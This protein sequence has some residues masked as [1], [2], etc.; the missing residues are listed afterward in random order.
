MRQEVAPEHITQSSELPSASSQTVMNL[1]KYLF[2]QNTINKIAERFAQ[3]KHIS[4]QGVYDEEKSIA[5]RISSGMK[6]LYYIK[7]KNDQKS[8][9]TFREQWGEEAYIINGL[10]S[11]AEIAI[12]KN[13]FKLE[14][15]GNFNK[16]DHFLT[17][18][19]AVQAIQKSPEDERT[20]IFEIMGYESKQALDIAKKI[21]ISAGASVVAS[22]PAMGLVAGVSIYEQAHP[23]LI[24]ASDIVRIP[25]VFSSYVAH[26][27]S[28]LAL[29]I[30][31]F[32]MLEKDGLCPNVQTTIG[33]YA[34]KKIFPEQRLIHMLSVG[35]TTIG[36]VAWEEIPLSATWLNPSGPS[37]VT[38]R[39]V[40]GAGFNLAMYFLIKRW[41]EHKKQKIEENKIIYKSD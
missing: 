8:S 34:A 2:V 24:N 14:K 37:V 38:G 22:V 25:V 23:N 4:G 12:E 30:K 18:I 11:Q 16:K 10:L 17:F 33:Y 41:V 21:G 9:R 40:E 29:T 3:R 32:E 19:S 13:E 26:Y 15:K 39:N 20:R 1:Q 35:F 36:S 7:Q 5:Q 6:D 28:L 31:N 27:G